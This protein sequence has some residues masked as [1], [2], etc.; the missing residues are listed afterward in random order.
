[1]MRHSR[2]L[3]LASLLL[4]VAPAQAVTR[5]NLEQAID[6]ALA[7]D[8]RIDEK[9][10]FVNKAEALL[11]EVEGK[12]GLLVNLNSYLALTT[13]V[14]GGFYTGGRESCDVNCQPR[15]DAYDIDNVSLWLGLTFSIVKPLTTF[16]QLEN[17]ELAARN[18]ILIKQQDV[19]LEKQVVKLQ[20]V[21]A[22]NGF[23]AARDSRFLLEDTR[24]RLESALELV[25]GWLDEGSGKVKLSDQYALQAG[26]GLVDRY[27]AEASGLERIAMAGLRLLTG[28]AEDEELEVE[29]SRLQ[30]VE[31]PERSLDQ[32]ISMALENRAEFKQV[33]AGLEARRA[34]VEAKRA[35]EKP[36]V[37][38]GVAGSA[39]YTP[40]RAKLDNPFLYDP[41]NHVAASPLIGMTWHWEADAQPAQ[42]EQEQA[43]LDALV[44]KASFARK[45]I[46]FEVSEQYHLV[47][48]RFDGLLAMKQ[49]ALAAR[50]WMIAAYSDFEA[51]LG[52]AEKILTAMQAYVLAYTD[53]VRIVNDFNNHVSKL[54]SVSGVYE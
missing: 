8:P 31:L 7:A 35:S 21:Q 48:A 26:L 53:Y 3:L 47:K 17:Y 38:A 32:W 15:D 43:E 50:R 22:Y 10:A 16:G 52:E 28:V 23:L 1:M 41:F 6:M 2:A 20:V 46:P 49:S 25:N 44:H 36:I 51:G 29:D 33:E 11:R 24:K 14:D 4:L 39:A 27:L 19:T 5:I 9:R 18:S 40:G 54:E 30:P 34:L 45:G 37:Y 13:D 42:V 12:G